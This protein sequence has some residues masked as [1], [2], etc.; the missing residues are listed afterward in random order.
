MEVRINSESSHLSSLVSAP[1]LFQ[2]LLSV[3]ATPGQLRADKLLI[4]VFQSALKWGCPGVVT[5]ITEA[6]FRFE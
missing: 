2:R 5:R 1:P 6:S 3:V 4:L